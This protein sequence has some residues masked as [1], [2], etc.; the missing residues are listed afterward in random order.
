MKIGC[1]NG[2]KGTST[3]HSSDEVRMAQGTA[4]HGK[5]G[6]TPIGGPLS[7]NSEED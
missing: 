1:Q 5:P 3:N 2:N 7:E 4:A 6:G